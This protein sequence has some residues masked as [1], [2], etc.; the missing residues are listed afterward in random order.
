MSDDMTNEQLEREE[1]AIGRALH[2]HDTIELDV[3]TD[4]D[5]L[6][7]CEVV[8]YLPFD[9]VT[10]PDSLEARVLDAARLARTPEVPSLAAR[11]RRARRI[12]A[13]GTAAAVTA[14]VTLLVVIGGGNNANGP[15]LGV[16][17][18]ISHADPAVVNHLLSMPGA[19]KFALL[20]TSGGRRVARVVVTPNGQGAL[21]D[22]NLRARAGSRYSFWIS[23]ANVDIRVGGVDTEPG[24]GFVF[25]VNGPMTGAIISAEPASEKHPDKPTEIV[26]RGK[27]P[28]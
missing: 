14:A 23:G 15:R 26:A 9:E 21:Y 25:A 12:V 2:A 24:N 27:L 16:A 3:D 13:V 5:V 1:H 19:R 6:E 18:T 7:Y 8:S 28:L 4:R 22:T 10:P 20:D 11:R 17:A